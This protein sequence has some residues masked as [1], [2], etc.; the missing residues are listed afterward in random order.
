LAIE[1]A[2]ALSLIESTPFELTLKGVGH[3]PPRG[4]PRVLW[5]GV[6]E[7]PI[8][9]QL[10]RKIEKTL[11]ELGLPPEK[12]N[13]QP[14]VTVARLNNTPHE[15]VANFLAQNALLRTP[16]FTVEEYHLVSSQLSSKGAV[17]TKEYS[18]PLI[19]KSN[20]SFRE[21]W[22]KGLI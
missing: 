6:E 8:L 20:L 16:T 18:Y 11:V 12:R 22:Q 1:I 17:H 3:A 15:W 10:Q 13:F 14:H 7:Q 2:D 9:L 4:E 5:I 21:K 19:D